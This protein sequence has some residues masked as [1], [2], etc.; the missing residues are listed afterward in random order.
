MSSFFNESDFTS[1]VPLK[2]KLKTYYFNI[3]KDFSVASDL[4]ILRHKL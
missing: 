2:N 1:R 3:R 4:N